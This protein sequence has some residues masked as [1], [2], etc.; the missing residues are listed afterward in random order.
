M[1][2]LPHCDASFASF[3]GDRC[4]LVVCPDLSIA[5]CAGLAVAL[6]GDGAANQGQNFEAFNIAKLWDIPCIFVCENNRYGMVGCD[7]MRPDSSVSCA[8]FLS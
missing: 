7:A 5:P 4:G 2:R 6:Y 1:S 8:V 3:Y